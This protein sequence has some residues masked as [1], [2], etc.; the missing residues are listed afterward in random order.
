MLHYQVFTSWHWSRGLKDSC[1]EEMSSEDSQDNDEEIT[2]R[3][4]PNKKGMQEKSL[5]EQYIRIPMVYF[6][7]YKP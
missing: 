2:R 3:R 4:K 6:L 5:K 7:Q 1:E